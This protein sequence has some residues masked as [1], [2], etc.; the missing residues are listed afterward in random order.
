MSVSDFNV[1]ENKNGNTVVNFQ[2]NGKNRYIVF[3]KGSQ[4]QADFRQCYNVLSIKHDVQDIV[5]D[6]K[7]IKLSVEYMRKQYRFVVNPC[8]KQ[9]FYAER[10]TIN[11]KS[12]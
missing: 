7:V 8:N 1:I 5:M 4:A 3:V 11:L 6:S 9:Y 10:K 12:A 2:E